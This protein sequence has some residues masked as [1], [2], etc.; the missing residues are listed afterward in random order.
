VFDISVEKRSLTLREE[1]TLR[2]GYSSFTPSKD[3]IIYL[4]VDR[5]YDILS[6]YVFPSPGS[7]LRESF[8]NTRYG[9]EGKVLRYVTYLRNEHIIYDK[10]YQVMLKSK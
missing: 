9:N 6:S 5:N 4:Y 3:T 1:L 10:E 8:S 2:V 7:I